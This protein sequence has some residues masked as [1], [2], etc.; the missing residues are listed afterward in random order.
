MSV[1][2]SIFF[3]LVGMCGCNSPVLVNFSRAERLG[4]QQQKQLFVYFESW[5]SADCGEMKRWM[6]VC[7]HRRG[8]TCRVMYGVFT[9]KRV[10][11]SGLFTPS[12][13]RVSLVMKPG[14]AIRGVI[15]ETPPFG[16]RCL[17]TLLWVTFICRWKR[18]RVQNLFHQIVLY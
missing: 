17:G 15:R 5:L 1:R 4:K 7:A 14:R 13:N 8:A 11:C 10:S 3:C 2:F 16:H 12:P 18:Q 9:L 6:W